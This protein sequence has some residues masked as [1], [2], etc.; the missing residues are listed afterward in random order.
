M[1][2]MNNN[3]QFIL[4]NSSSSFV[5]LIFARTGI[6]KSTFLQINTQLLSCPRN[7]NIFLTLNRYVTFV[8]VI[9]S[10]N[11]KSLNEAVAQ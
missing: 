1:F 8:I 6:F 5:Q 4:K 9:Q 7:I 11:E 3:E 10:Q 2:L